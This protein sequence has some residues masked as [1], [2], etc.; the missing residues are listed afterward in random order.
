MIQFNKVQFHFKSFVSVGY[1][2]RCSDSS[3]VRVIQQLCAP[4]VFVRLYVVWG[5]DRAP[6]LGRVSPGT[7]APHLGHSVARSNQLVVSGCPRPDDTHTRVA[8]SQFSFFQISSVTNKPQRAP[9]LG[10]QSIR[11]VKKVDLLWLRRNYHTEEN[12]KYQH[13]QLC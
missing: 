11:N 4:Q 5:R 10:G 1:S 12:F 9:S 13:R 7:H 3:C 2:P 6:K 8:I